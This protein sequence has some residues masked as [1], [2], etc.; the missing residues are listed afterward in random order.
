MLLDDAT[1]ALL[2]KGAELETGAAEDELGATLALLDDTV[3]A[4]LLLTT[5]VVDDEET[6]PPVQAE[7][8]VAAAIELASGSRLTKICCIVIAPLLLWSRR[9]KQKS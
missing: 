5:A 7:S 2:G 8:S 1:L 4:S 9:E 6:S 3:T